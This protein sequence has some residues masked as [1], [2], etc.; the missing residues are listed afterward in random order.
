MLELRS[1]GV[2]GVMNDSEVVEELI[3]GG[4]VGLVGPAMLVLR[5]G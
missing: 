3:C 5:S 1:G 2:I 4:V